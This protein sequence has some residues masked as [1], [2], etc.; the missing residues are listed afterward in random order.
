MA[1][2][3]VLEDGTGMASANSYASIA[4]G[5]T[6]HGASLYAPEWTNATAANKAIAL[7]MATRVIDSNCSF[8]GYRKSM[9][10]ALEW[11][12]IRAK[13][14]DFYG[15]MP[16]RISALFANYFDENSVPLRL[17]QAT[18]QVA[19]DLL[20]GDRTLE[21]GQKGLQS[22]GIGQGAVSVTFAQ[23]E[24]GRADRPTPLTEEAQRML[25]KMVHNFRYGHGSMKVRRGQ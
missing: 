21:S 4:D 8:R 19:L 16:G 10:Q 2:T 13:N 6:Y 24:V 22:V 1:F 5:D 7:G 20:R 25:V 17:K 14:D 9:T 15:Q 11:P 12:R 18:A 23:G 3:L